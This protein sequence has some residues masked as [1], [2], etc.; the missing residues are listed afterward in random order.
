MARIGGGFDRTEELQERLRQ[1]PSEEARQAVAPTAQG[2][3]PSRWSLKVV[4]ATFPWLHRTSLSGVWRLL[5]RCDLRL[6]SARLQ[7]YSPDPEY[8]TKEA[9]LLACLRDAAQ[10]PD[11]VALVFLDEMG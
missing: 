6:R 2:P 11:A 3:A 1:V 10:H 9:R 8:G 5:Q 4:R 7:Q